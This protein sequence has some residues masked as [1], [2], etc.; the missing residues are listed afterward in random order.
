[1]KRR[2]SSATVK[3][4]DFDIP[5]QLDFL[6]GWSPGTEGT[7]WESWDAYLSDYAAVRDHVHERERARFGDRYREPFAELAWRYREEHG[8]EALARASYEEIRDYWTEY[9]DEENHHG[10]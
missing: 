10:R 9:E 1:M 2:E 5:E 3:W 8:S 7:R 4:D 6:S